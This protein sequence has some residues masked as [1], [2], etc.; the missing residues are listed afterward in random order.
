MLRPVAIIT[1]SAMLV[2]T[3]HA[4]QLRPESSNYAIP[5]DVQAVGGGETAKSTNYLLDDTIG[6][7]NIGDSRSD[8]YDLN[9]GY[10]QTTQAYI[11]LA[12]DNTI[13]MGTITLTGQ[14]DGEGECT[15]TT[16]NEG[17]YALS[18]NSG[19]NEGLVGHWPFDETSGSTSY[20]ISG[21]GNDGTH[22]NG[23]AISLQVPT[24]Y[25]STRSVRMDGDDA[26]VAMGSGPVENIDYS[27]T[28]EW[29]IAA[30]ARRTG[31]PGDEGGRM[32]AGIYE[33]VGDN[34]EHLAMGLRTTGGITYAKIFSLGETGG[35]GTTPIPLNDWVH[36]ALI[37]KSDNTVELYVNGLFEYSV[38]PSEN[39]W[40]NADEFF[41][42][43]HDTAGE[44]SLN[45]HV[46]DVRLYNRAI[47]PAEIQRLSSF[48]PSGSLTL[49]GSTTTFIEPFNFPSTGSVVGHWKMEERFANTTL[50]DSSGHGNNGTPNGT[51]GTNNYPQ[52]STELPLNNP[53]RSDRSFSFDGTDDVIVIPDD[54]TL[55]LSSAVTLSF[56]FNGNSDAW[57]TSFKGI[58][59]K[60]GA[61]LTNFGVN[62][63]GG[64]TNN[65][66][67]YFSDG[68][69]KVVRVDADSIS[70]NEWH[71][72]AGTFLDT[73][74]DVTGRMYIDGVLRETE[75]F[76][77]T[78]IGTNN[79]DMVIG[80][81][82]ATTE[83]F[84][85]YIDDV[86]LFSEAL[87]LEEIRAL[88]G[89]PQTWSV[90]NT[91]SAWGARLKSSSDDT[92]AKWGTD[93]SSEAFLPILDGEYRVVSRTSSNHPTGS[94]QT[95]QMRTEIG[96][97]KI[98][99]AG[100]YNTTV[101]FTAV[102]L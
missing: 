86:R 62:L 75:I 83:R 4:Q 53:S 68:S 6:E 49:S 16:D 26:Y 45:G 31:T 78:N 82:T 95:F 65:F 5:T 3:V 38:T 73:G 74:D 23:A 24:N 79:D 91:E 8:N 99:T 76:E 57:P 56:W 18:W 69:F 60:R 101:V 90:G 85:G 64:G 100:V 66:Q 87:S 89:V 67:W 46:D 12:C 84:S 22:T 1:L 20:D 10:R 71:H 7:A 34:P 30:W 37:H 72:F 28:G 14:A 51:S 52:P 97:H 29:T 48:G 77:D 96:S 9:A 40:Q 63:R 80:A 17:G 61:A 36:Y 81:T 33:E 59:A 19:A 55:D 98:Q 11:A 70:S 42:S 88:A 32:I 27:T 25:F 41:V 50:A 21:Y 2:T 13:D 15:V 102:A 92:D 39:N 44:F 54:N 93:S 58:I 47:D 35:I 43:G 94:T